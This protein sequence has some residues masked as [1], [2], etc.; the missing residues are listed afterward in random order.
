MGA[1]VKLGPVGQR[2]ML[3]LLEV[4]R[5]ARLT[6]RELEAKLAAGDNP[7]ST[8]GLSKIEIGKRRVDVDDLVALAAALGIPESRLLQGPSC[9]TCRDSI[10]VGFTCNTCGRAGEPAPE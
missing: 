4:R 3:N 6:L 8:D 9:I 5:E 7:I 2:V 10:P 1:P